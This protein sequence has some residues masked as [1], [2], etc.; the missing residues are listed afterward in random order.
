M[1]IKLL[2]LTLQVYCF[3]QKEFGIVFGGQFTH[4]LD[5]LFCLVA[6]TCAIDLS[7]QFSWLDPDYVKDDV[8]PRFSTNVNTSMLF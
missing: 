5:N 4:I 1:E 8:D 2:N 3:Q 6:V 7:L